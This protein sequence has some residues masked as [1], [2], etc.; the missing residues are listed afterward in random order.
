MNKQIFGY[1]L[2]GIVC[3]SDG[4][5][6]VYE[7][8]L[9]K[10]YHLEPLEVVGYEGLFGV[11]IYSVVLVVISYLPCNFGSGACVITD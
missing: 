3:I 11:C 8:K 10:K 4:F 2:M 5:Y 7:Q 6:Y 9:L 1:F